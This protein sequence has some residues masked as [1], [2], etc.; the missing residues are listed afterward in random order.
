ME[1]IKTH[2][3]LLNE[4]LKLIVVN[5]EEAVE[6]QNFFNDTIR[7]Y[8][9]LTVF[10]LFEKLDTGEYS[11]YYVDFKLGWDSTLRFEKMFKSIKVQNGPYVYRLNLPKAKEL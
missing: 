7:K 8:G 10:N 4:L 1:Q 3:K 6:L 9:H 2:I 5:D 11:P